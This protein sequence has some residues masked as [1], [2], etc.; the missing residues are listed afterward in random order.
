MNYKVKIESRTLSINLMHHSTVDLGIFAVKATTHS[1]LFDGLKTQ[2][3]A[4]INETEL[5]FYVNEKQC[6]YV[7]FKELY[8][9]LF[10]DSFVTFEVDLTRQIEEVVAKRIVKEYPGCDVNY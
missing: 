5:E 6:S 8:N 9:K 2:W 1:F 7:G 3:G 4:D 10:S